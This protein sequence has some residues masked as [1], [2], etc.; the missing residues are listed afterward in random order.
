MARAPWM[1]KSPALF[2]AVKMSMMIGANQM[3][4]VRLKAT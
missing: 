4:A 3:T 1:A 2:N